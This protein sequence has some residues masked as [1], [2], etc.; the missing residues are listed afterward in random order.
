MTALPIHPGAPAEPFEARL[1]A[2]I[3]LRGWQAGAAAG[4]PRVLCLHGFPEGPFV[5]APL[6]AAL[7]GRAHVVAPALRGYAPSSAPTEVAAY[8]ARHLVEDVAGLV[9]L[10]GA[11]LDVLVAHD[12]GGAVAWNFAAQ[13]P[14]L[15]RELVILNA[16][17]PATLLK[18]LQADPAQ[19]A[20][21][22]YMLDL[23][24]DDAEVRLARDDHAALAAFFGSSSEV[25]AAHRAQWRSGLT[26][27]LNFY[28]ASPL[29]PP[30]ALD[31]PV[32]QLALPD[33]LTRVEVP[34]TVLWGQA[35]PALRPVLLDGLER[36]VP[37][38]RVR[39]LPGVGHWVPREAPEALI[40][41]VSD[42]LDRALRQR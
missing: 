17:H 14:G 20:A 23:V 34:T 38:L 16:P 15:L 25:S 27:A 29:R 21:S 9:R 37:Q 10:L 35:D 28:R 39:R 42:A 36:W 40:E 24:R 31:D 12:W 7:A 32:R 33:S 3:I 19:Q 26:G 11:P 2:D 41:E 5:W 8:R 6:L 13:H 18:A 30:Q 4:R 22:A 1:S